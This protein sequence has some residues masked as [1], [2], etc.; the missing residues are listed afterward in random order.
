MA[1]TLDADLFIPGHGDIGTKQ[2]L[3]DEA[4]LLEDT[5]AAVKAAIARGLSREE[6]VKT[7]HLRQYAGLRQYERLH[8]FLES[9]YLLNTTGSPRI[10]LPK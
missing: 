1:A 9:L 6:I 10:A 2:D 8:D 4:T 5:Q 7:V 3:L